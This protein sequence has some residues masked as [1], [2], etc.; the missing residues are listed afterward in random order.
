MAKKR[1]NFL[2]LITFNDLMMQG[3]DILA[4]ADVIMDGKILG[5]FQLLFNLK[6]S[7][8]T[9]CYVSQGREY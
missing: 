3:C 8:R 5:N 6:I 1:L 7:I 4:L 2:N 9:I